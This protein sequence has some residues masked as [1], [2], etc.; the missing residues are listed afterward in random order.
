MLAHPSASG[1]VG[2]GAADGLNRLPGVSAGPTYAYDA[3]GNQTSD[4][5]RTVTYDQDGLGQVVQVDTAAGR[6]T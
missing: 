1:S 6:S 4:G 5:T 2:Y 3:N